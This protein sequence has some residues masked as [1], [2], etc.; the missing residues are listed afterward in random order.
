M[1]TKNILSILILLLSI[2]SSCQTTKNLNFTSIE[3]KLIEFLIKKGDIMEHQVKS[4]KNKEY[5]IHLIGVKNGY[6]KDTLINGI[7]FF[8]AHI[9]HTKTYYLIV[10]NDNYTI[11]DLSNREGLDVSIKNTLDFC[12]R[13]K[14][15]SDITEDYINRIIGVYYKIN[16][17]PLIKTDVNCEKETKHTKDLP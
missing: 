2:T 10:E 16:K 6:N 5:S 13:Q 12:E 17:N 1:K 14:Y 3:D 7:Y 15:C 11:L 8:S 9:S 4:F